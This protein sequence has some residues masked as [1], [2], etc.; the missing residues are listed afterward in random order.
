MAL[1]PVDPLR[2]KFLALRRLLEG[3]RS[4]NLIKAIITFVDFKKA[5]DS[6][7]RQ[8]DENI[9]HMIFQLNSLMQLP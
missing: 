6:I 3:V 8:G 5:L 9:K 4:H 7:H 1:D 2:L